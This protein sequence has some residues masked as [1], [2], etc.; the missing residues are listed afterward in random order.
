MT[1]CLTILCDRDAGVL[2]TS[3]P[4]QTP[5][6][7]DAVGHALWLALRLPDRDALQAAL[8]RVAS[9]G[10]P[11]QLDDGDVHSSF[12]RISLATANLGAVQ[13]VATVHRWPDDVFLL[14]N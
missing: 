10:K 8:F 13:I 1:C 3:E 7:N 9:T 6:G 4:L 2:W 5:N 11:E 14:T 12:W